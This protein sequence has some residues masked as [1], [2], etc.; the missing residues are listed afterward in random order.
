[1]KSY[2]GEFVSFSK[3]YDPFLLHPYERIEAEGLPEGAP[4]PIAKLFKMNI[5]Y[6]YR[7]IKAKN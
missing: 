2:M 1:M 5:S 6:V 7:L 4:E 3:T